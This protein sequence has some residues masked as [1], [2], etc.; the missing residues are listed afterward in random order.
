[1]ENIHTQ[2]LR[3]N[4]AACQMLG[5]YDKYFT[6]M[7]SNEVWALYSYSILRQPAAQ[8]RRQ[9]PP[10]YQ[11]GYMPHFI[12][13]HE[14]AL[15]KSMNS[16]WDRLAGVDNSA[17]IPFQDIMADSPML[18]ARIICTRQIKL[19]GLFWESRPDTLSH[20]SSVYGDHLFA[21]IKREILDDSNTATALELMSTIDF[22]LTSS[23]QSHAHFFNPMPE[24]AETLLRL[25]PS[26]IEICKTAFALV[27]D[28]HQQNKLQKRAA[29]ETRRASAEIER[30][31]K[32]EGRE[33]LFR[34]LK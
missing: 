14:R 6:P 17:M 21:K 24:W 33:A 3:E 2:S 27:E 20:Y 8:T 26:V 29:R 4:E 34:M 22:P 11:T 15:K 30:V 23:M 18:A 10:R 9:N 16:V 5:A 32:N 28:E 12:E 13:S 19:T 7:E 31:A 25:G 1:M